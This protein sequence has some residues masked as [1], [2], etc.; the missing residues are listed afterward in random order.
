[1]TASVAPT[2]ADGP[3]SSGPPFEPALVEEMLRQLDK[4]LRAHQMYLHNNPTYL[5]ALE[6]LRG[7]FPPLWEKIDAIALQVSDTQ[8]TWCGVPVHVSADKASDS[9]PWNLYKDGVRELTLSPGFEGEELEWLL[10]IIPRVRRA[11]DHEDDLLT[12]L[13]EQEFTHLTY[14]YVDVSNEAGL[15]IDPSAEPGRWPVTP[16]EVVEA[17]FHAV[18]E[19]RAEQEQGG[20]PGGGAQ[21]ELKQ[22]PSGIVRMED[23][24]S[25]LYFLDAA[26]VDYLRRETEREYAMDLRQ[27]VLNALLDI[28]E[29]QTDPLVRK[30][31][32]QNLDSLTLHL[33]A[34][35]QFGNV[36]YLLREIGVVLER[37]RDLPPEVRSRLAQLPD[38]LSEPNALSQ[39]LEAMDEAAQLPPQE[40]L[41]GL[42]MQLRPTALGTVFAW[43]GQTQN[44]KLRP[45]LEAAADRLA[46]SNTGE[47]VKLIAA[48]EGNVALEAVRRAGAMKA[49]A[50]VP[51]LT[52]VLGE[53]FRD[54]RLAA[55]NA[56]VEI[57]SP[58]AL[59]GLEKALDDVDR[60]V[61][62]AAIR[63]LT[64]KVYKP[65]LAR[66]TTLVKAKEIREADRTE[67]LAMFELF[68]TVCGDGGV[69]YLD[70]LLNGKG[71]IFSRKED[72]ELR[73]CAAIALGRINTPRSQGALQKASGEK[74]VVVRTAVNRAL[75]GGAA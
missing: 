30:E 66:V 22:S 31:I 65:A 69:A 39:L 38:R 52:K 75:K 4:T 51:P 74:D 43:L 44:A 37:A 9:V 16:G 63:A 42:F 45:L 48:A 2:S 1:M 25:T 17:P 36:A 68:G 20:K 8:L 40:E 14:R 29:L 34:G 24:D 3:E 32:T 23:F 55:V 53:Q 47:L 62:V 71:G 50:A 19:A 46:Q 11:Q 28:F 64:A 73:A 13:W 10:D 60:D 61:R 18:E 6:M 7:T 12:M 67:R 58:G 54:L 21:E 70:E 57:G 56:L 41:S 49:A 15:P 5:R 27:V 72:P 59:Q 26:E 35:R 33:L